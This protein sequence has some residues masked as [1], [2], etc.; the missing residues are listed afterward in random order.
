MMCVG[1]PVKMKIHSLHA[2]PQRA[3]D[4]SEDDVVNSDIAID[5]SH[6][7]VLVGL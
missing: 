5:S 3:L 7:D 2:G 6:V 4:G 1:L